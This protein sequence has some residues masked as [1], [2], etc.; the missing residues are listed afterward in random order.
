M[1]NTARRRHRCPGSSRSPGFVLM[2]AQRVELTGKRKIKIYR[3]C[4]ATLV[5]D[6]V[7]PL[8]PARDD[9]GLPD[10]TTIFG[11]ATS[12]GGDGHRKSKFNERTM[13]EYLNGMESRSQRI[14]RQCLV[15]IISPAIL[16][17]SQ[18]AWLYK[19]FFLLFAEIHH[20]TTLKAPSEKCQQCS[21]QSGFSSIPDRAVLGA[22]ERS[23]PCP[24]ID[25]C[26]IR[27]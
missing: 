21:L 11:R 9:A 20:S 19:V 14:L 2:Q 22:R 16:K 1:G 26:Q 8:V 7:E 5:S 23:Q 13:F 4:A 17:H 27:S 25:S 10:V 24:P 6:D 3:R 15:I 18:F 12:K